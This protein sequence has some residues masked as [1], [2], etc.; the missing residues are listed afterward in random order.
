[1][2]LADKNPQMEGLGDGLGV[3]KV[4]ALQVSGHA[5]EFPE[6]K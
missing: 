6:P 4:L 1:M 2:R 5:F 3:G